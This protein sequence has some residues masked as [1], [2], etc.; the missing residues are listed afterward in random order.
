[1]KI[2][3]IRFSSIGDIILTT[4]II[5]CV[6]QRYPNAELHLVTKKTFETIL[7]ANPYLTK[8]HTLDG[9]IQPLILN[10]LKEKFEVIIDLHK[11]FRSRFIK[12]LMRQAF[13]SNITYFTFDKLNTKKW[14]LTNLKWNLLPDKSIVERYF[15][16]LKSFNITNDG[17]G[18][19]Y[20]IPQEEEIKK[21]D[22]PMSH[23]L[24]YIACVIGGAHA[25]KQMPVE[26]WKKLCMHLKHPIILLGG[27]EDATMAEEIK[28]VDSVKIYN[29]CGKFSI[30]ESAHLIKKSKLVITH[31]TGLM[32]IAAAFKKN[33]IS[34]WGNT[35]PELGMFPYYGFNNLKSNIS[36]LLN[37]FQVNNLSCRPCSKIGYKAC[38]KG[39]FNC[40]N[41]IQIME[42][43]EKANS[44]LA[45]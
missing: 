5:R 13:N 10:L 2:L 30:H 15:E 25:T 27:K 19:D 35:I 7:S 41:K 12:S 4:P 28:Q 36:P 39:H 38:P 37:I 42:I 1:M 32:H 3:I 43:I 11:N 26:Q 14:L 18:L 40:M 8:I 45:I 44:I 23:V 31:D 16:G 34:I 9:D 21:D 6:K 33:I 24:G 22:I 20:F 17:Q 29:A